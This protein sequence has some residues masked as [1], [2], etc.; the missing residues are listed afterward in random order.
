MKVCSRLI[1]F[2][3]G[4]SLQAFGNG[5][6]MGILDLTDDDDAVETADAVDV[7]KGVEHKVLIIL[8]VAGIDLYLEIIITGS[9]VALG[10]QYTYHATALLIVAM[11]VV[12]D[13][14]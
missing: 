14:C 7:A 6:A 8:H 13:D 5:D 4:G 12:N 9:V 2:C 3:F 1:T 10:Y 11:A